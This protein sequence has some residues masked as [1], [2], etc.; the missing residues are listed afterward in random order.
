MTIRGYEKDGA[1]VYTEWNVTFMMQ[2]HQIVHAI[3]AI[4][5]LVE[6]YSIYYGKTGL[7]L[8]D[9]TMKVMDNGGDL[10]AAG[11]LDVDMDVLKIRGTMNDCPIDLVFINQ[12]EFIELTFYDNGDFPEEDYLAQLWL[13]EKFSNLLNSMEIIGN[14]KYVMDVMSSENECD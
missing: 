3:N 8:E 6:G 10:I 7:Q 1:W 9:W 14:V 12:S 11:F 13:Y 4:V 2:W 5:H